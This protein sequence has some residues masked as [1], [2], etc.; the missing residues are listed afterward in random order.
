M[1][2]VF[3]TGTDTGVGKAVVSAAIVSL[4]RSAA[5]VRYWKPIQT[6]TDQ[7]DDTA[8]VMR[9][10]G[11]RSSE[12]L[13]EGLRFAPPVSPHLAARLAGERIDLEE[14][15]AIGESQP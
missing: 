10:A 5:P 13:D 1:R 9:L 4:Y 8:E 12:I 3:V 6:G 2:G 15:A 14:V 7:D 11:C